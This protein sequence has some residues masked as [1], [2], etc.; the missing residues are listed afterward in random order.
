VHVQQT[1]LRLDQSSPLVAADSADIRQMHTRVMTMFGGDYQRPTEGPRDL[2]TLSAP[3]RLIVQ[4]P[5]AIDVRVLPPGYADDVTSRRA[6]LV[7]DIG[8]KVR[9]AMVANPTVCKEDR[10]AAAASWVGQFD[11]SATRPRTCIKPVKGDAGIREW[12][13]RHLAGLHVDSLTV[14]RRSN[15]HGT[16]GATRVTIFKARVAG[17]GTV[18]DP[19]AWARVLACGVGR[20]KAYGCGLV[21]CEAA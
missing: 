16:K 2:W 13:A 12:V 6:Q 8:A 1:L 4:H 18:T 21:V 19:A 15:E 9:W 5:V 3:G 20:G 7:W 11:V 14:G 17:V 10:R